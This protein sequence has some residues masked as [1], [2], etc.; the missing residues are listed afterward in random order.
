MI[1]QPIPRHCRHP[2]GLPLGLVWIAIPDW[3]RDS[4]FD[5]R[6]VGLTTLVHAPWTFK[7]VWSPLMD[8]YRLPWLGRRRGWIAIAQ[9]AL[10]LLTLSLA[11][12]GHRPDGPW[13]ILA[14][15][16]AIAFASASQD[17]VIDA[18]AVDVLKR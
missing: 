11:G 1:H 6:V 12:V 7:M 8:R 2:T 13:I 10:S 3:M 16:L 4:G 17:I 18:Y 14:I 5:I 15:G 9:I